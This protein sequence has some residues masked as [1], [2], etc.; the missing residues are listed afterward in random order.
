[1]FTS[2]GPPLLWAEPM[3]RT[4]L[5]ASLT[6]I[7]WGFCD[8]RNYQGRGQPRKPGSFTSARRYIAPCGSKRPW[9]ARLGRGKR[10]QPSRRR[11]WKLRSR[12][13]AI[14]IL[15]LNFIFLDFFLASKI[16]SRVWNFFSRLKFFLASNIFSRVWNFFSRLKFFPASNIFSGLG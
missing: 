6:I 15:R 4:D 12:I 13:S 2:V 16:F 3:R 8:M 5:T 7:G 14:E 9:L 10:Y 11:G 1:M